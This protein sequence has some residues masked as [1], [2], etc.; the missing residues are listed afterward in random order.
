MVCAPRHPLP[1]H[2]TSPQPNLSISLD[3]SIIRR[4]RGACLPAVKP[5][6]AGLELLNVRTVRRVAILLGS[7]DC[8]DEVAEDLSAFDKTWELRG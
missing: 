4:T 2:T 8:L 7:V 1:A 5:R 6:F 3:C